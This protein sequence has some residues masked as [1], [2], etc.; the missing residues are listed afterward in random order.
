MKNHTGFTLL[1]MLVVLAIIALMMA[2]VGPSF[3][4]Q[5]EQSR[6]RLIVEQFQ[7]QLTQLP[8]WAR[9]LG[10]P[11]V[12]EKLTTSQ[13]VNSDEL[14]LIPEGWRV[15]FIPTLTVT[16]NQF[17]SPS[18]AH[19]FDENSQLVTSLSIASPDCDSNEASP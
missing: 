16:V 17:C 14:L 19:L 6:R 9:L 11:L 13:Y 8:R 3:V 10:E 1:E 18:T 2:L 4:H 15:E 7:A 12:L 5:L